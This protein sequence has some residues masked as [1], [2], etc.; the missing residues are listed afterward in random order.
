M[1]SDDKN[2]KENNQEKNNNNTPATPR[3]DPKKRDEH[4]LVM[5]SAFTDG[6]HD[7]ERM[8]RKK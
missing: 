8:I 3:H 2:K 5:R 1:S 4:K 7:Y 6:V